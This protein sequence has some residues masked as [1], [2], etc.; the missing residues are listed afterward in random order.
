M[1]PWKNW[2][3]CNPSIR[4]RAWSL[5]TV[6]LLLAA[7]LLPTTARAESPVRIVESAYDYTFSDSLRFSLRATSERPIAEA[8]LFYGRE[9]DR[10]VRRVYPSFT[11]GSAVDLSYTEELERGQY[12][13]GT[14]F[15]VWWRFLLDD[16]SEYDTEPSTLYY[17]DTN[18]DWLTLSGDG[19]ELLWYGRDEQAAER[20]L[21]E[22]EEALRRLQD[23]VGVAVERIVFVYVYNSARDMVVATSERGEGYDEMVTTLGV[24]VDEDTLLLLGTH[25]DAER[26]LAHELSHIV[27]GLRTDN[28]FT[29]LPRWLDEG[30]AMYAEGQLPPDNQAALERA[31]RRDELL[32]VRSL[33]S[34]TGQADQV[35]LF[36]G[37]ACSVV[38]FLLHTYG[39]EKM[40]E[41]L[42]VFSEGARQENALQQVY[43]F[44]LD[45]LDARWRASLGLG[46][47]G[48]GS[49]STP[50]AQ[51]RSP[52]EQRTVCASSIGLLLLPLLGMALASRPRRV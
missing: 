33:T 27:V 18:Q 21:Q 10:L 23:E 8:I 48:S 24:V 25:R 46:P 11:P 45:E 28:P 39:R 15:R 4:G 51:E 47:R 17:T 9:G 52:L 34:Y 12:A 7:L 19:M 6:G 13:P 38:S 30:L 43:G 14:T 29:D 37:E 16:G 31:V 41:L 5:C 36:Y 40:T 20:L 35:D 44:G 26:T 42:S 1:Y 49:A 2:P 22:G 50:A 32:S 3:T